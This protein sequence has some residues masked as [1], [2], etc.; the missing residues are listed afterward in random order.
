MICLVN[1]GLLIWPSM[2][3]FATDSALDFAMPLLGLNSPE[4]V[5]GFVESKV[6]QNNH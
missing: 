3:R 2:L 5:A 6:C 1:L 4:E